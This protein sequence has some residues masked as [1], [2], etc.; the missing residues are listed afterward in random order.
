MWWWKPRLAASLCDISEN[1]RPVPHT[2]DDGNSIDVRG[3]NTRAVASPV[4]RRRDRWMQGGE[5]CRPSDQG[6]IRQGAND[7]G[8]GQ[9]T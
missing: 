4:D 7:R 9:S 8:K 2:S 1:D 5:V 6:G 3:A